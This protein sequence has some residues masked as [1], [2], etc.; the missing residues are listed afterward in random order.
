MTTD[1]HS[2][3][4]RPSADPAEPDEK[5]ATWDPGQYARFREE[6]ARPFHDLL[7]RI[8]DGRV[9]WA[10]DLGCGTGELTR[11]LP[12]RWP[13][14]QV[15]GI[16][17]S[18]EML[19]R[20]SSSPAGPGLS[21]VLCDLRQWTPPH[22]VD[23]IVSNAALHW[24]PDHAAVLAR[25]AD[26]LAPGGVLGVQMP[27]N[28]QERAYQILAGLISEPR[29][30][31]RLPPRALD[32][33]VETPSWYLSRLRDL[34]LEVDLWETVYYHQL[35]SPDGIVEWLKGTTLR[36]ILSKLPPDETTEFV[37][38]LGSRLAVAYPAGPAGILFPFRRLFFVARRAGVAPAGP[39]SAEPS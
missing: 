10:A 30:A 28:R 19:Q 13:G 1:R 6:R 37:T 21:F 33:R 14:A 18:A 9:R 5:E 35:A 34:G 15:W 4:A 25:L 8:P 3:T 24:V 38:S 7:A 23:R 39:S 22:P 36:I 20:A 12:S 16:D 26:H 2:D 31:E 11:L 27:N 32:Q 29:W 17:R